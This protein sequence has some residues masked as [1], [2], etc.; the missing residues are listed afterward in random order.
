MDDIEAKLNEIASN[1][2]GMNPIEMWMRGVINEREAQR[3]EAIG[4][5]A[6]TDVSSDDINSIIGLLDSYNES[7]GSRMK[8][9]VVE[10]YGEVVDKKYHHGRCDVCSPFA[11]GDAWDVIE[12]GE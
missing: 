8:L 5:D 4:S 12:D 10:G 6:G 1:S 9:N 3:G 2:S 7:G 11:N